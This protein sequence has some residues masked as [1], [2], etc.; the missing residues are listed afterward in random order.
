[1]KITETKIPIPDI[2]KQRYNIITNYLDPIVDLL[3]A[4]LAIPTGTQYSTSGLILLYIRIN[5]FLSFKPSIEQT[6]LSI[7]TGSLKTEMLYKKVLTI[8][9]YKIIKK[10]ET[11]IIDKIKKKSAES[12]HLF[13]IGFTVEEVE[14]IRDHLTSKA[15]FKDNRPDI[16]VNASFINLFNLFNYIKEFV[17]YPDIEIFQSY[18]YFFNINHP[19]NSFNISHFTHVNQT[20]TN[21]SSQLTNKIKFFFKSLINMFYNEEQTISKKEENALSDLC[22]KY[23]GM[24]FTYIISYYLFTTEGPDLEKLKEKI[25]TCHK[26]Y[27]KSYITFVTH[28]FIYQL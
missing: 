3:N 23:I 21:N 6:I 1:M 4:K 11:E 18:N 20:P 5:Q 7:L 9:P 14:K 24:E 27:V 26:N 13:D 25:E 8:A 17:E 15:K 16:A 28:F 19:S 10:L 2:T 12:H 22:K